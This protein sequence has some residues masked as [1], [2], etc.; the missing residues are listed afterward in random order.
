[1]LCFIFSG[2]RSF[3]WPITAAS[4]TLRQTLIMKLVIR[5]AGIHKDELAQ[6]YDRTRSPIMRVL[7]LTVKSTSENNSRS[8]AQVD[9]AE[10][11]PRF[12]IWYT[13]CVG[14]WPSL[15]SFAAPEPETGGAA[16]S[17]VVPGLPPSS[18]AFI[19]IIG[20]S[21]GA[22]LTAALGFAWK[23]TCWLLKENYQHGCG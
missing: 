9:A 1:M 22:P 3:V 14:R 5:Y 18:L 21:N 6:V 13:G 15:S 23:S 4:G 10:A 16:A 7:W 20:F 12:W 17:C 11:I 2:G 19:S 8:T